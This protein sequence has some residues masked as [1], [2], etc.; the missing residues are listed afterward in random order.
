MNNPITAIFYFN[1]WKLAGFT[2]YYLKHK[3]E[4]H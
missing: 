4:P 2:F 1:K 3:G